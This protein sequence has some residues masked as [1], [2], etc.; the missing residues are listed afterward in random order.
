MSDA[1]ASYAEYVRQ[2]ID[3]LVS[4]YPE[5]AEDAELMAGMI[6]GETD[7]DKALDIILDAF[8]DKIAMKEAVLSRIED[9]RERAD[10]FGRNADAY[11]ELAFTLMQTANKT[12]ARRPLGTLVVSKGRKKLELDEDFNAQGYMRVKAEPMRSDILAALTAG[13]DI[14]GARLVDSD[15]A[16]SI[17]TK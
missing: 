6:E 1:A 10:R 13:N 4:R 2:Q 9:A 11:K 14:P 16:L 7:F 5:I 17:R 15:P 12:M 8:L 3:R